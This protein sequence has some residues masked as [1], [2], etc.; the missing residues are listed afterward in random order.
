MASIRERHSTEER[1]A[2]LSALRKT[3][4]NVSQTADIL[5]RSRPAVYRLIE[6]YDIPLLRRSP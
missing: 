6:K 5:G 3:G 1:E 2:L 4:G